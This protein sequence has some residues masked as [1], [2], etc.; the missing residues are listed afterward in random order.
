[1]SWYDSYEIFWQMLKIMICHLSPLG[2]VYQHTVFTLNCILVDCKDFQSPSQWYN[3]FP[4]ALQR[5]WNVE[6]GSCAHEETSSRSREMITGIHLVHREGF[7]L[8]LW[9]WIQVMVSEHIHSWRSAL[10][11]KHDRKFL[12]VAYCIGKVIYTHWAKWAA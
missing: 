1:M 4:E 9:D 3:H 11:E 5:H 10:Y 8:L 6:K 7:G 12:G 2:N